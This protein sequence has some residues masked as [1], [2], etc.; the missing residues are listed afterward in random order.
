VRA[1]INSAAKQ[2]DGRSI[3]DG[4]AVVDATV[5]LKDVIH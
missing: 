4:T 5:G 2:L 1:G 3:R